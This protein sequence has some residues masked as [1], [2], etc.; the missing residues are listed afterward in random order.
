MQAGEAKV[1]EVL[2]GSEDRPGRRSATRS[3]MSDFGVGV[4][5]VTTYK[6]KRIDSDYL[7]EEADR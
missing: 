7:S 4:T 1:Q 2:E 5:S 6:V 3:L